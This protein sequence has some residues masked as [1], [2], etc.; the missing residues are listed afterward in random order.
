MIFTAVVFCASII[1]EIVFAFSTSAWAAG[2]GAGGIGAAAG[3]GG[4]LSAAGG[5]GAVGVVGGLA[6][7][8]GGGLGASVGSGGIAGSADGGVAASAPGGGVAG[9][10]SA[11]GAVSASDSGGALSAAGFS[12]VGSGSP[13]SATSGP[14]PGYAAARGPGLARGPVPVGATDGPSGV[15]ASSGRNPFGGVNPSSAWASLPGLDSNVMGAPLPENNRLASR[16]NSGTDTIERRRASGPAFLPS[17]FHTRSFA[18]GMVET[19]KEEAPRATR[20][21]AGRWKTPKLRRAAQVRLFRERAHSS[22]SIAGDRLVAGK[23]YDTR[24]DLRTHL[25]PARSD[26]R[27]EQVETIPSLR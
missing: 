22:K 14:G 23:L 17:S 3:V 24:G 21:A 1:F 26:T 25:V 10:A 11:G 7:S 5:I 18:D 15:S 2:V 9:S 27:S 13:A 8:V 12:N 6:G 19:S 4:A 20:E 16:K